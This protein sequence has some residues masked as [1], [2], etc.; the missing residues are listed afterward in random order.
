VRCDCFLDYGRVR[1][2]TTTMLL[3][4]DPWLALSSARQIEK[5]GRR[6]RGVELE[7]GKRD[8]GYNTGQ[9]TEVLQKKL[10]SS[11]RWSA[12]D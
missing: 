2:P 6:R 8:W 3:F 10:R 7:L 1:K 4:V 9:R 5:E 11:E 12:G